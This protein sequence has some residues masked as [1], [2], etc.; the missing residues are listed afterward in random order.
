MIGLRKNGFVH[1]KIGCSY[2]IDALVVVDT[3]RYANRIARDTVHLFYS[4]QHQMEMF[5]L[6]I[7]ELEGGHTLLDF[8]F[9]QSLLVPLD[10]QLPIGVDHIGIVPV[11]ACDLLYHSQVDLLPFPYR[12]LLPL[13]NC[14]LQPEDR[15][16]GLE[17]PGLLEFDPLQSA[18]GFIMRS[19]YVIRICQVLPGKTRREGEQD[20]QGGAHYP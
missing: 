10:L 5:R 9:L 18:D 3:V 17:I 7:K 8:P 15:E 16:G 19:E 14:T 1:E 4:I 11:V 12:P 6:S 20:Q 13:L 2:V